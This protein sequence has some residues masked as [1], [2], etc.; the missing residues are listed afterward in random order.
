VEQ[1]SSNNRVN[2][3]NLQLTKEESDA[4]RKLQTMDDVAALYARGSEAVRRLLETGSVPA[5]PPL[6]WTIPSQAVARRKV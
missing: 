2:S 4:I 3:V 1:S 6:V 5:P